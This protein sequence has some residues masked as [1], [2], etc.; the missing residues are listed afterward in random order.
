MLCFRV[1]RVFRS[2][3]LF[4]VAVVPLRFN[5]LYL[6]LAL[7]GCKPRH[8]SGFASGG[9]FAFS[10]RVHFPAAVV[11]KQLVGGVKSAL[12]TLKV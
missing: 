5:G 9:V 3:H 6:K 1:V 2:F 4:A 10:I 7:M 11:D 8:A 12:R